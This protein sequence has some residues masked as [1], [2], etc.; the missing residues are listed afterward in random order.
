MSEPIKVFGLEDYQHYF[1]SSSIST[2]A[3]MEASAQVSV[4]SE[5]TTEVALEMETGTVQQANAD[6]TTITNLSIGL[7]IAMG[8]LIGLNLGKI[9]LDKIWR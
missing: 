7:L 9:F 2:E 3:D 6:L 4:S 5:E 1:A 8:L